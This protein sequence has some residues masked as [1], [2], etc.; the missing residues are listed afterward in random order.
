MS[1]SVPT[2]MLLCLL[3][4]IL[5]AAPLRLCYAET[6]RYL[7]RQGEQRTILEWHLSEQEDHLRIVSIR[8]AV[9]YVNVCLPS[10]QTLEWKMK[11]PHANIRAVRQGR[12]L[13]I[14]GTRQGK[15]YDSQKTIGDLPWLQP[16]S[17]SLRPLIA[18][19]RN[20]LRFWMIHPKNLSVHKLYAESA[21]QEILAVNGREYTSVR[22]DV[23]LNPLTVSFSK[24]SYWFRAS[25]GLFLQFQGR[26]GIFGEQVHI[27][28]AD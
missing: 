19:S 1:N 12:V 6:H 11:A 3:G 22:V 25:D 10:G 5:L 27:E 7:H 28:L 26:T 13:L 14:S 16:L 23:S 21:A 15:N 24:G 2:L 8:E 20:S 18:G 4:C 17:F 9:R